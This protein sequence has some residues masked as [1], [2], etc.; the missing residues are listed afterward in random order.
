L[1]DAT[2]GRWTFTANTGFTWSSGATAVP[3]PAFLSLLGIGL[4]GIGIAKK[5]KNTA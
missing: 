3:E 2:D 5:K 1:L 4:M